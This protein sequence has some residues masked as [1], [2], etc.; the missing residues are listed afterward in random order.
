[1]PITQPSGTVIITYVD[2]EDNY[3]EK[4]LFAADINAA[5]DDE[6]VKL[7]GDQTIS[8]TKTFDSP[9]IA[10]QLGTS[11]SKID[12]IYV[13]NLEAATGSGTE[14]QVLTVTSS[15]AVSW[16]DP[17]PTS[18][19]N[20]E[21]WLQWKDSSGSL[22]LET[23]TVNSSN[24]TILAAPSGS[25]LGFNIGDTLTWIINTD[26][27]MIPSTSG[28]LNIGSN[29]NPVSNLFTSTV[30]GLAG[31][32]LNLVADDNVDINATDD[33]ILLAG[34]DIYVQPGGGTKWRF[35]DDGSLQPE[36]DATYDLGSASIG[37]GAKRLRT[38]YAQAVNLSNDYPISWRDSIDSANINLLE[39]DSNDDTI[40]NS[41]NN[42]A[43]KF[44]MNG[45]D[46]WRI[47][48]GG[49]NELLKISGKA[50]IGTCTSNSLDLLTNNTVRW[51]I[52]SSGHFVPD[53]DNSKSIGSASLSIND[54]F[55]RN[56][57]SATGARIYIVAE[58]DL[59]LQANDGVILKPTNNISF[60]PGAAQQWVLNTDGILYPIGN[61]VRDIG[62]DSNHCG[63]VHTNSVQAEDGLSFGHDDYVNMILE[64]GPNG[65]TQL[66]IGQNVS[67]KEDG[68][69]VIGGEVTGT[70]TTSYAVAA[71]YN[72]NE[73]EAVTGI[74][75]FTASKDGGD[76][77]Q[78]HHEVI[79]FS[80]YQYGATTSY[81][82]SSSLY[83]ADN[84]SPIEVR[85][86]NSPTSIYFEGRNSSGVG[87]YQLS[88]AVY[89][90]IKEL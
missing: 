70:L 66:Q 22:N 47:Y 57:K 31:G 28:T 10:S 4:Q 83:S 71:R 8:G 43:I 63:V 54:F 90:N 77:T 33:I 11:G 21:Q 82:N 9:L 88:C 59:F 35:R 17:T 14:G 37:F 48:G 76:L 68:A 78:C 41:A 89:M 26:G 69:M 27:Y 73:G 49:D 53:A 38:I 44:Q 40:L 15:G 87:T 52:N 19:Y 6:V 67:S 84:S 7:T 80:R 79:A 64:N 72:L 36:V 75:I 50:Q 55:V 34:D 61:G 65:F 13:S 23:L 29:S 46:T 12:T 81:T 2:G 86:G 24:Q 5:L 39:L 58:D 25:L 3:Q 18:V 62:G 42:R 51:S 74:V 1:M 16:Q 30:E 32:S 20:N 45:T 60:E 85:V 56:I